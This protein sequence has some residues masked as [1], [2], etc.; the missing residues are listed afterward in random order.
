MVYV[1]KMIIVVYNIA[2][3]FVFYELKRLREILNRKGQ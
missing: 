1:H 3:F 2:K